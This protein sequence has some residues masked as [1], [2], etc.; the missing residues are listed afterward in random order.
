MPTAIIFADP[1]R[2]P[3]GIKAVADYVHDKGLKFGI[4]SDVGDHTCRMRPG[5]RGH[6]YQDALQLSRAGASTT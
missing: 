5:S 4:Y 3:Q 2:F 6:E 1:Q